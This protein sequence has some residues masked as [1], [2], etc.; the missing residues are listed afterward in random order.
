MKDYLRQKNKYL[1]SI[2]KWVSEHGG[3]P[4]DIIPF[5]VEFEEKVWSMRDDP[6]QLAEFYKDVK[7]MSRIPKIVTEGFTKLGLQYYFTGEFKF[8]LF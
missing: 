6:E 1:P 5:S 4:T 8:L 3:Q 7:V 2:A